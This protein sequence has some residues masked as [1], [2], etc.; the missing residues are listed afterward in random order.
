MEGRLVVGGGECNLVDLTSDDDDM[1]KVKKE[2]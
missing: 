1:P 2:V